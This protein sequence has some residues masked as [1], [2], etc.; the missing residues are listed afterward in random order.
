MTVKSPLLRSMVDDGCTLFPNA[1]SDAT[2][3]ALIVLSSPYLL[4][5][6]IARGKGDTPTH[7]LVP[8][9]A[10][11]VLDYT[12][13]F[14]TSYCNLK[15]RFCSAS[16]PY[17]YNK[18]H[19]DIDF[20]I[21][22]MD[23]YLDAIYGVERFR[24]LGGEPFLHPHL[25]EI[26]EHLLASDKVH[27]IHIITNGAIVPRNERVLE[28]LK[29]DRVWLDVSNYGPVSDK[30]PELEE[31]ERAGLLRLN[32][33]TVTHWFMP[34]HVYDDQGLA[35]DVVAERFHSCPDFCHV[36]R[37]GK[38]FSC[39]EAFHI[40]NIPNSP[41]RAG[42]D[43]VDLFDD[44]MPI[45]QKR[46]MMID[47]AFKR[48]PTMVGCNHCGGGSFIYKDR[49]LVAGEQPEPGEHVEIDL[50]IDI[51]VVSTKMI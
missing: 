24:I 1:K 28:L 11:E 5:R 26:I 14:I 42:V 43:Y 41:M 35:P 17:Y 8:E 18:Y 45:E 48:L 36:L 44:T 39:G 13:M 50:P 4:V 9:Q 33:D 2:R 29:N 7:V 15:C 40:A 16:I 12:E 51:P 32:I 27:S 49:K 20:L 22:Q 37:D 34:N 38:F 47:V 19:I 31:M 25:A 23:A 10:H 30:V 46:Q 6:H 21:R 3:K